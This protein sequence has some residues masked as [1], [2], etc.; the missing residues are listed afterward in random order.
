VHKKQSGG[1]GQFADVALRFEPGEPGSG[2]TFKSEIKGGVV[3]KEY[4]PGVLK[5]RQ[6]VRVFVFVCVCEYVAVQ[7]S[8]LT[9]SN[10]VVLT[11][12]SISMMHLAR[13]DLS[14]SAR[15]HTHTHTRAHTCTHVHT[16]T[17][18]GLTREHGQRT[19]GWFPSSGCV[20][21]AHRW[22]IPR[23]GLFSSSLPGDYLWYTA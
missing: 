4:I 11:A 7:T 15:T 8:Q 5:V 10:G 13:R 18:T 6:F 20:L 14:V 17:H 22:L 21:R 16:F 3:P 12:S 2:F 23:C 9:A 1:S 19:P